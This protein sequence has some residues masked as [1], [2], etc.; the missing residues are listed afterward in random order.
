A[1]IG[2]TLQIVG[3][4][5]AEAMDL[6]PDTRV[7]DVAAGNGNATL[8]FARRW[9]EVTS[10]DYVDSLLARGRQ[11]AEADGLDVRFQIADAENL[12]FTDGEFDAVVSTFGVMFTPNQKQAASELLRVVRPGG[13]IGLA[14]WTPEGFIGQLFKT[15]GK[16]IAPPAGVQSP[17]R[18]GTRPWIDNVFGDAA[19]SIALT[20]RNFVFRYR[21]PA[22]F[23]EFFRTYYGPVHKAFL[24]L[25]VDGQA[26][27]EADLHAT[28]A[29]LNTATDGSMRVPAEYAEIVITR[30]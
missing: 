26:A 4:T 21:S 6:A 10:T 3:E 22:H 19:G 2:T 14:N 27:L 28:I 18:W 16:H 13:H 23:V 8:A 1:K 7:L 30:A 15:L 5:L 11:R 24:A 20:S 9:C 17:A 29:A 12:P 25:D